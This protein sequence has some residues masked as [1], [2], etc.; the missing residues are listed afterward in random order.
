[1]TL[2]PTRSPQTSANLPHGNPTKRRIL[3]LIA[4]FFCLRTNAAAGL[5]RDRVT[6]ESDLRSVRRTMA[7]LHRD[8]FLYRAPHLDFGR[9]R[10][11]VTYVYGLSRKGVDHAFR[12]GFATP[13]TKTLRIP[14]GR[15]TTNWRSRRSILRSTASAPATDSAMRGNRRISSTR[16]I[17]TRSSR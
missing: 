11:G 6:T 4:E 15:W 8:G 10:G 9:E 1:M 5:L 2:G 16:S 17:R 12:N 3:E 14:S 7:I 13:A